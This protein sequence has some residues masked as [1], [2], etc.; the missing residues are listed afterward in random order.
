VLKSPDKRRP[1]SNAYL[2]LRRTAFDVAHD[3]DDVG[4]V[5]KCGR[6]DSQEG[7]RLE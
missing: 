5:E 4:W 1:T 7:I 6:H 2:I 3:R